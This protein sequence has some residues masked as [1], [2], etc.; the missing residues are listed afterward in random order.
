MK[1][2][3][4]FPFLLFAISACTNSEPKSF[5]DFAKLDNIEKVK[6]SN[7]SGTFYLTS[8]QLTTF[9]S[10]LGKLTF[11]KGFTAKVGSIS[12]QI[13]INHKKYSLITATNGQYIEIPTSIFGKKVDSFEN[14]ES[15][16]F[17][18]NGVNF[19]NYSNEQLKYINSSTSF[20]P[21]WLAGSWRNVYE[22]NSNNFR[23]LTFCDRKT[24][25]PNEEN[26]PICLTDFYANYS[27]KSAFNDSIYTICFKN[28]FETII[29]EFKKQKESFS[30]DSILTYSIIK[31]GKVMRQHSNS[32]NLTFKKNL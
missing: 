24:Y 22:S 11:E 25:S 32:C 7:N 28:N 19:D 27:T 2:L 18:S 30:E 16:Y 3:F 29:Y 1:Q 5:Y 9:Q 10:D 6:I 26:I 13:T 12:I 14:Q 8:A 21:S 4:I 15:V 23:T 20:T 31:N 17:K